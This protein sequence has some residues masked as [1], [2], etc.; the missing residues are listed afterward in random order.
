MATATFLK[1]FLQ[2]LFSRL[3]DILYSLTA[4]LCAPLSFPLLK[5]EWL[6]IPMNLHHKIL[7]NRMELCGLEVGMDS[8]KTSTG[9]TE[10]PFHCQGRGEVSEHW[11]TKDWFYPL[12]NTELCSNSAFSEKPSLITLFEIATSHPFW[13]FNTIYCFSQGTLGCCAELTFYSFINYYIF[14]LIAC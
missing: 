12:P 14:V 9:K 8:K 6:N 11:E 3:G 7:W 2:L 1:N 10:I 4:S 5:A 13:T